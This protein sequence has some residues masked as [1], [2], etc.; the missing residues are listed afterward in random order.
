[1]I[2]GILGALDTAEPGKDRLFN[3]G[4]THPHTVNE[5]VTGLETALGKSAVRQY[6][7]LPNLVR[8]FWCS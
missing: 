2:Q 3:L 4:N 7:E 6:V 1:M 8:S 5:L